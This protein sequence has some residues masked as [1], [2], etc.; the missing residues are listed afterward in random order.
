MRKHFSRRRRPRAAVI[1]LAARFTR[2]HTFHMADPARVLEE[3]LR[4][5]P[6]QRG[7][8]AHEVI[9]SLDDDD[10]S[11]DGLWRDEIQRRIDEVEAGTADLEEW[12][13]LRARLR[14]RFPR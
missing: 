13:T 14:A 7:Q 10:P 2:R 4:L 12:Q 9:R 6:Q 3:A 5:D 11:A 8:L 1:L